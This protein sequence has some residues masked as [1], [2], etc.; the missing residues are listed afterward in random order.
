MMS[1]TFAK[2]SN[3]E[4]LVTDPYLEMRSGFGKNYPVFH[5]VERGQTVFIMKRKTDWFKVQ[6]RDGKTGWVHRSQMTKTLT[7]SGERM[8]VTEATIETFSARNW[9]AGLMSGDFNGAN[10]INLFSSYSANPTMATEVSLSQVLGDYSD[11]LLI[12]FNILSQP[13]PQWR[14]SPFFT[15]GTGIIDTHARKSLVQS[16]DKTDQIMNVGLGAKY[17]ISRRFV[18]RGDYRNYVAFSSRND[19]KEFDEWKIGISIFY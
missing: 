1:N 3:P 16:Q 7:S 4:V 15:L 2:D 10:V 12:G 14:L 11:S 9:E 6:T 13:F 19:N 8:G 17:Y 18:L 5:V